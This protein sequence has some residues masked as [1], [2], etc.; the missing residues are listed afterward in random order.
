MLIQ[1][2]I[3]NDVNEITLHCLWQKIRYRVFAK[4]V[5]FLNVMVGGISF[6]CLLLSICRV[7]IFKI[8]LDKSITFFRS[9]EHLLCLPIW[10]SLINKKSI[11]QTYL[12]IQG[13]STGVLQE[14][15]KGSQ[16]DHDK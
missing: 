4:C 10:P 13:F 12:L 5:P 2:Y 14:V 11:N 3:T 6:M 8:L 1:Q 7:L 16:R 9:V 15:A